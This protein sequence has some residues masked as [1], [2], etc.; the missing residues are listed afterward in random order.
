MYE[1]VTVTKI[2]SPEMLEVS[3]T[4]SA[5]NGCKGAAFCNTKGKHFEA[6][7]KTGLAVQA[8]QAVQ[9]YLKPSRTIAGTLITLIVPLALFPVGYY[10]SQMAGF[11]EGASFLT[12][13]SSIGLGFLGV[14]FYFKTSQ[15]RYLPVVERILTEESQD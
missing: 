6:W 1:I 10:L 4:S 3:C 14:W 13:L 15:K 12:A 9:I 2:L 8:G 11:S 5:C 7:N